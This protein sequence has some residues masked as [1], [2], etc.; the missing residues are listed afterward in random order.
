MQISDNAAVPGSIPAPLGAP[1]RNEGSSFQDLLS[2]LNAYTGSNPGQGLFNSIL[3]QLG[4]TPQ[5]LAQMT[6]AEREKI[7]VKIRELMKKEMQAQRDQMQDPSMQLIQMQQQGLQAG[8]QSG[9]Q[10]DTSSSHKHGANDVA[11]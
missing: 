7:E 5:Q 1:E 4:I 2:Q 10:S 8:M 9:T 3:A 6:P 11:L